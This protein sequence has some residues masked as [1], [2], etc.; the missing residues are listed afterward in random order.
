M[1]P[2]LLSSTSQDK[3]DVERQIRKLRAPVQT[4]MAV[5]CEDLDDVQAEMGRPTDERMVSHVGQVHPSREGLRM[6]QELEFRKG[7]SIS[8]GHHGT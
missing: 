6:Q 8:V 2:F 5:A 4:L 1:T 3:V 7:G